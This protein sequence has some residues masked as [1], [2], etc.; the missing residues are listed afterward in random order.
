MYEI[1]E[2]KNQ[3]N[4]DLSQKLKT[5]YNKLNKIQNDSKSIIYDCKRHPNFYTTSFLDKNTNPNISLNNLSTHSNINTNNPKNFRNNN[6]H[7]SASIRNRVPSLQMTTGNYIPNPYNHQSA[8]YDYQNNIQIPSNFHQSRHRSSSNNG[9]NNQPR[10]IP[11]NQFT[12]TPYYRQ[13]YGN[14]N[15]RSRRDQNNFR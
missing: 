8:P 5:S 15:F 3:V 4:S 14:E 12:S 6:N 13:N 7:R 9:Y 10:Y 1:T 11:T 2:I